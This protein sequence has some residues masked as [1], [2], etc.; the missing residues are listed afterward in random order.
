MTGKNYLEREVATMEKYIE[1]LCGIS[2]PEWI[3]LRNGM[4]AFSSRER[5]E[6][7]LLL[8]FAD[9]EAVKKTIRSQFG[10]EVRKND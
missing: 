3:K 8:E 9:T 2:Y 6:L 1:A 10:N 7:E 5:S 4:D